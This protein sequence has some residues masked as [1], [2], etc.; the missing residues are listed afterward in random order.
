MV[1]RGID[2]VVA[3]ANLDFLAPARFEDQMQLRDFFAR[4]G[5][6]AGTTLAIERGCS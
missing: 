2:A 6:P 3:E 1:A 5:K 4:C